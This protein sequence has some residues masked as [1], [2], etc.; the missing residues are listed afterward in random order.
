MALWVFLLAL[1]A[2]AGG[3]G[4]GWPLLQHVAYALAAIEA[5]ALGLALISRKAVT[6]TITVNNTRLTAGGFATETLG[7]RRAAWLPSFCLELEGA[8]EPDDRVAGEDGCETWTRDYVFP[9]RGNYRLGDHSIAVSDPFGLFR[10]PSCHVDAVDVTVYPRPVEIADSA[11]LEPAG[12]AARRMPETVEGSI[13]ELRPYLPGDSLSRI[14]WRSS[15][16][17]GALVVAEPERTTRRTVWLAVDLGGGE[18]AAERAAGV[19]AY[20]AGRLQSVT[21]DVGLLAGGQEVAIVPPRRGDDQL[22]RILEALARVEAAPSSQ[23]ETLSRAA[24]RSRTADTLILISPQGGAECQVAQF[25]RAAR[26]V[27][28][29]SAAVP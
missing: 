22:A 3:V 17:T 11:W 28:F 8:D 23:I 14:H 24:S 5:V 18:Q 4:T 29:V 9:R 1:A 15:A 27:R 19:A 12:N 25:R 6:A 20:I 16:R 21:Q 7:I 26:S 10:L 13:G 2:Y